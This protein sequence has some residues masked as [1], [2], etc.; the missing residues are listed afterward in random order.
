MQFGVEPPA[1]S[2]V[3][4]R[5]RFVD[6]GDGTFVITRVRLRP[7]ER[8]PQCSVERKNLLFLQKCSASADVLESA[9][10]A[11]FRFRP[12]PRE[13]ARMGA[14]RSGHARSPDAP[15][16]RRLRRFVQHR[17]AQMRIWAASI[18]P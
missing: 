9:R 15:V 11:D 17:R 14:R 4:R 5:E 1:S 13:S 12:S 3:G 18:L 6:S 8:K 2:P 7:G 10:R 16:Q